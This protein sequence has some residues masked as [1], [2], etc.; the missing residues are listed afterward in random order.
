MSESLL[1]V[2]RRL[3]PAEI[4]GAV[5]AVSDDD[6]VHPVE[7]RIIADAVAV[8]RREFAAGRRA[9]RAAL[10]AWGRP[11]AGP[12]LPDDDL[13]PAWP[14]GIV[15]SISHAGEWAI[16]AVAAADRYASV[17]IDLEH[18]DDLPR[19]IIG[20]VVHQSEWSAAVDEHDALFARRVFCIKEA[21]YKCVFPIA[22]VPFDFHDVELTLK[23]EHFSAR[24]TQAGGTPVPRVMGR[25]GQAEGYFVATSSLSRHS[26]V[27]QSS[28]TRR[29]DG[30]G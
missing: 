12:L 1:E 20:S 9:A 28:L 22:R 19:E 11:N 2:L 3:L 15:G 24:I 17:G 10:Q 18:A 7:A 29:S 26:V 6:S 14:P 4:T 25:V 27:V 23:G 16:A 5:V 8:R 13:V 30:A 21:V